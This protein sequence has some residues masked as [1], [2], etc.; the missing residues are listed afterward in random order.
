MR[1]IS[2]D[3][4]EISADSEE[5][6]WLKS[7]LPFDYLNQALE[8]GRASLNEHCTNYLTSNSN[9]SNSNGNS[10]S[11]LKK[12]NKPPSFTISSGESAACKNDEAIVITNLL[13]ETNVESFDGYKVI[14]VNI[15]DKDSDCPGMRVEEKVLNDCE[16]LASSVTS[17]SAV[18]LFLNSQSN[19]E[20]AKK[21]NSHSHRDQRH[22]NRK[23]NKKS[24]EYTRKEIKHDGKKVSLVDNMDSSYE[25]N[26]IDAG[27]LML[28]GVNNLKLIADTAS[29]IDRDDLR[30]RHE[31][32]VG[33][34]YIF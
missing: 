1:Q 27:G 10:P 26:V 31:G 21:K 11:I 7:I 2:K 13:K 34:N 12:S 14:I 20:N 8:K 32:S 15:N 18:S 33:K 30:S 5:F 29:S 19:Q 16:S 23:T 17:A 22:N 4:I 25:P 24:S 3:Q 6:K 28:N 9:N